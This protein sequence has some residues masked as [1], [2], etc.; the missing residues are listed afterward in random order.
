[1]NNPS[2]FAGA[3]MRAEQNARE[4]EASGIESSI[5][6]SMWLPA[7]LCKATLRDS[8]REEARAGCYQM[9]P[10]LFSNYT[11]SK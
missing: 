2:I 6:W 4:L 10:D 5:S 9:H 1:M 8:I 7:S 11:P 3:V